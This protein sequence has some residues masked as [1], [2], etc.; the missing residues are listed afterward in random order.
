MLIRDFSAQETCH[1][2]LQLPLVKSTRDH[3]ILS[4]DGF[5]QIE[6]QPDDS[7][8]KATMPSI[9]DYY[10][11][12]PTD[13]TF[14]NIFYF[15]QSYSMPKELGTVPTKRKMVIVS[16]RPYCPPDPNGTKYE[17]YCQ[18]KLMLHVPFRHID[19]LGKIV[20]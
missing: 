3:V 20:H 11:Q 16:V 2:P 10:I 12:R 4:L 13:S 15:A 14:K 9:L 7:I 8:S 1:L 6:E 18:R 19:Q 5:C 17:Q